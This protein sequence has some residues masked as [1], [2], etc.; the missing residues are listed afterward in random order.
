MFTGL[1]I[2][3]GTVK[4]IRRKQQMIQLTF[5]TSN[6]VLRDYKIG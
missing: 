6:S 1:I 2:E 3:Q 4:E 5:Q